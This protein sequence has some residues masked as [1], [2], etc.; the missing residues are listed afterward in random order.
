MGGAAFCGTNFVSFQS[1]IFFC[2]SQRDY[3]W[4]HC[5]SPHGNGEVGH[6]LEGIQQAVPQEGLTGQPPPSFHL[7][8]ETGWP[9]FSRPFLSLI[10]GMVLTIPVNNHFSKSILGTMDGLINQ[11]SFSDGPLIKNKIKN[12]NAVS[13]SLFLS[14]LPSFIFLARHFRPQGT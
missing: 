9:F 8:H 4:H 5:R 14:L 13:P 11:S 12:E 1:G 10:Q 3:G 7:L 6:S 2:R